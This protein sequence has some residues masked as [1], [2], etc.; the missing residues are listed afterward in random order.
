MNYDSRISPVWQLP[1]A[2]SEKTGT[3]YIHP[4]AKF[5]CFVDC[6]SLCTMYSQR[7]EDYDDGITVESAAIL[8]QPHH[9][10]KRCLARWKRE[11]QVEG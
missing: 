4:K 3:A 1:V 7:T 8:E 6:V 11:Y 5:H 2:N 9:V 10:C